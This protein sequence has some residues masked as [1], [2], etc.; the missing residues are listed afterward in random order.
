[1]SS[2]VITGA[3]LGIARVGGETAPLLMTCLGSSF[4]FGGLDQPCESLPHT[5]YV[6]ALGPDSA[7]N[8]AAW[9]AS[10]ILVLMMLGIAITSRVVIRLRSVSGRGLHGGDDAHGETVRVLRS[11][12]SERR[13]HVV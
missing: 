8:Q 6:F 7:L 2:A 4:W 3:L 10:L 1:A 5:I 12:R 13:H 11:E 9:G